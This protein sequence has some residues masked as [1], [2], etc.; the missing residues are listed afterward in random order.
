MTFIS[1]FD[2][3]ELSVLLSVNELLPFMLIRM[4]GD[5]GHT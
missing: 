3:D 5:S 4:V 1:E 2:F